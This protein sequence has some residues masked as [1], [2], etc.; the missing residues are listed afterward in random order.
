VSCCQTAVC[1]SLLGSEMQ[2]A[3][4]LACQLASVTRS[5]DDD[6]DWMRLMEME[7]AVMRRWEN[8]TLAEFIY[9]LLCV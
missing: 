2:Q 8:D 3:S 5:V 1:L 9:M 7:M 4:G 6:D